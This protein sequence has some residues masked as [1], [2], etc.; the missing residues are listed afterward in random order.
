MVARVATTS[1]CKKK[2]KEP[3]LAKESKETPHSREELG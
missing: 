2:T 1:K 3:I